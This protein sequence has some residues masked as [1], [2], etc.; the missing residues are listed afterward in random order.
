MLLRT[1][2][3]FILSAALLAGCSASHQLM[4][5]PNIYLDEGRYPDS[6]VPSLLKTNLVDILY[7]TDRA[8]ESLEDA[9]LNYGFKCSASLAFGSTVV[10]IGKD[11][12]G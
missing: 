3:V 11:L 5:T 6:R 10:E 1:L 12:I 9:E 8:Q 4:P 7:L 2:S